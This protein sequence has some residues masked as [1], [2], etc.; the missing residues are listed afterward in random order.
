[1]FDDVGGLVEGEMSIPTN[2]NTQNIG[3]PDF[4]TLDEPIRDTIV[5]SKV[6][7]CITLTFL[8]KVARFKGCRSQIC[9]CT[10]SK[11]E[12]DFTKRM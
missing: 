9:P 12:E 3:K 1:M 11:R 8:F 2:K 10:I 7:V 4:N 6:Y 5:S